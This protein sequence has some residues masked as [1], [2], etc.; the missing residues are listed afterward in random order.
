MSLS[1]SGPGR[2]EA[3]RWQLTQTGP[4]ATAVAKCLSVEVV[5]LPMAFIGRKDSDATIASMWQE[6]WEEGGSVDNTSDL[7]SPLRNYGT[8]L[9]EKL[10]QPLVQECVSALQDVS[11][12][13]RVAGASA[14]QDL[15][16]IGI[17]SNLIDRAGHH[18][19][20]PL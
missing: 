20:A 9:E 4:L 5:P 19:G 1:E 11:W 8:R 17:L 12:S 7:P 2:V 3:S 16:S 6:V 15:C 10:L 13:S 18:S 14:L